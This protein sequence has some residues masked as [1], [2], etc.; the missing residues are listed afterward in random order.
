MSEFDY[1]SPV[2]IANNDYLK[3]N[4][5]AGKVIQAI[6]V[7]NMLYL[8]Q[9]AADILIKNAPELKLNMI[10]I[11]VKKNTQ[12]TRTNGDNLMLT[13]GMPSTNGARKMES[14]GRLD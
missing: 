3:D 6:K 4:K 8:E 14:S 7:T 5:E 1:Y 11:L 13:A 10:E 12:A 9:E 2:I